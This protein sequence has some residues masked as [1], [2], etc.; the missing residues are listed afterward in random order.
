M[1]MA[2]DWLKPLQGNDSHVGSRATKVAV[3]SGVI[4]LSLNA[5]TLLLR[6]SLTKVEVK[7]TMSA[8]LVE[9]V[10]AH[11]LINLSSEMHLKKVEHTLHEVHRTRDKALDSIPERRLKKSCSNLQ[12]L[13]ASYQRRI[14]AASSCAHQML[15]LAQGLATGTQKWPHGES[16]I[17]WQ[18]QVEHDPEQ[19]RNV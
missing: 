17:S 13:S 2:G 1:G 18:L 7:D 16:T 8:R 6:C 5:N 14:V 19:R 11:T 10:G 15:T 12:G 4:R 3:R 9:C